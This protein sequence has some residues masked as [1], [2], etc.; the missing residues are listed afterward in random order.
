M[1]TG[2]CKPLI[3]LEMVTI[4]KDVLVCRLK[5]Y[6]RNTCKPIPR[7]VFPFWTEKFSKEHA[8]HQYLSPSITM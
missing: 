1:T 8:G 6:Q 5:R 4:K 2:S 7:S 3:Y